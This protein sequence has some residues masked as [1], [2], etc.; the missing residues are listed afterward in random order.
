MCRVHV[1]KDSS[2][3]HVVFSVHVTVLVIWSDEVGEVIGHASVT[4]CVTKQ[5]SNLNVEL[6]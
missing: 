1:V 2:Y 3:L 5:E 6:W 4:V